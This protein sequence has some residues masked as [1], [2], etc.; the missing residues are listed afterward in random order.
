MAPGMKLPKEERQDLIKELREQNMWGSIFRY[1]K[2]DP[3]LKEE[4]DK[5]VV[6]YRLKYEQRTR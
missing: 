6:Y 1:A 3:V 2:T 4:L 5:I